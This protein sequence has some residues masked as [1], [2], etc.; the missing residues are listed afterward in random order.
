VAKLS[1][2]DTVLLQVPAP[3]LPFRPCITL[4]SPQRLCTATIT[5]AASLDGMGVS[6]VRSSKILLPKCCL[7]PVHQSSASFFCS[8]F[9][10]SSLQVL[11][12][13]ATTCV[14]QRSSDDDDA[15]VSQ[16]VLSVWGPKGAAM[17]DAVALRAVQ[18]SDSL[19]A[20]EVSNVLWASAT[21]RCRCS[22]FKS[23]VEV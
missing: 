16:S 8:E 19:R 21:L 9:T 23:S 10:I 6:N 14:S 20:Q 5:A 2:H 22:S 18:I 17:I 1:L 15:V 7:E 11:W 4:P 12:G 3:P 13:V